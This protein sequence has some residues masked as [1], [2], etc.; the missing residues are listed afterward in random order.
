[1]IAKI[2]VTT[3]GILAVAGIAWFFWEP[4]S[5]ATEPRSRPTGIRRP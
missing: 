4:R 3:L 1:M 5:R 2:I